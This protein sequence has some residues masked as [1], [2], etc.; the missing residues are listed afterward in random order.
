MAARAR[1]VRPRH[2]NR[3]PDSPVLEPTTIVD[4]LFTEGIL[5][6]REG[7]GGREEPPEVRGGIGTGVS[8]ATTNEPPR[9]ARPMAIARPSRTKW[10]KNTAQAHNNW[11]KHGW[12][13]IERTYFVG[14]QYVDA[15]LHI[16]VNPIDTICVFS[17]LGHVYGVL[18]QDCG[19]I[20]DGRAC[21]KLVP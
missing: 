20:L 3:A 8:G 21:H 14:H 7:E 19:C 4:T 1:R 15:L 18:K 12:W 5:P 2:T 10:K 16:S 9:F 11:V 17:G 13:I 6:T